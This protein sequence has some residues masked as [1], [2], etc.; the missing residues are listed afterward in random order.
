MDIKTTSEL[1]AL[2]ILLG[3][4]PSEVAT[5]LG[6]STEWL[7]GAER[8]RTWHIAPKHVNTLLAYEEAA[9]DFIDEV[10][11]SGNRFIITYSN[12]AIYSTREP[13]WSKR[14]PT[15]LMHLAA[16]GRAKSELIS[17]PVHIVTF[18][19]KSYQEYLR[20][21]RREDSRHS[22]QAWAAAYSQNYHLM[23]PIERRE[24]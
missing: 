7:L 14:L 11:N 18:W 9:Q 15:S 24:S 20:M 13:G 22:E 6:E 3:L 23:T 4:S 19:E 2:R 1:K 5:L 21:T 10:V 8:G 16:A 17:D 12:N